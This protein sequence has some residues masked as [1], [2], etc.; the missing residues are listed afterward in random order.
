M[1]EICNFSTKSDL[2]FPLVSCVD[3]IHEVYVNNANTYYKTVH[4]IHKNVQKH[5]YKKKI[6][7][8]ILKRIQH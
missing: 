8:I 7:D 2:Y 6:E 3:E 4:H 5:M 1:K